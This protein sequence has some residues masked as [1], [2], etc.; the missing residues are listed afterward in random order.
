MESISI[1]LEKRSQ[2]QVDLLKK[3]LAQAQSMG[4]DQR[5]LAQRAGISPEALSRLKKGGSCRLTTLLS[6]AR[7][8][9][10]TKITLS[11]ARPRTATLVAQKLSA[12]RLTAISGEEL[13][14]ALRGK[15]RAE[16]RP[17]LYGFFEELPLELVHDLILDE[18]LDYPGL[19]ALA[20]ALAAEGETIDWLKEMA[21]DGLAGTARGCAGGA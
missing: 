12:G 10:L 14:L 15:A 11:N 19:L 9:G 2:A 5:T 16:H 17:H 4:L 18:G 7:A 20:R 6:L 1:S 21:G 13:V 8:V 3:L